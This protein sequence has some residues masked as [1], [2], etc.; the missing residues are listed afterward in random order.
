M[1]ESIRRLC[2]CSCL[3]RGCMRRAR[4]RRRAV[5]R[6]RGQ[7][8]RKSGVDPPDGPAQSKIRSKI[9]RGR[10]AH[11]PPLTRASRSRPTD[12][13]HVPAA[14]LSLNPEPDNEK[15]PES[16]LRGAMKRGRNPPSE[17]LYASRT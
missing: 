15:P 2:P 4:S 10:T 17:V 1:S 8:L 14:A 3:P 6:R 7:A 9:R 12:A 16:S 13:K 11:H 5:R